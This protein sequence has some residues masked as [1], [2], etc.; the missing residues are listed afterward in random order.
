MEIVQNRALIIN[1][2]TPAKVLQSIPKSTIVKSYSNGVHG[3]LVNWGLDEARVLTNL[4]FKNVPSP[5]LRNY[6]WP[7]PF[8]PFTHQRDTAAFLTVRKRAFCFNEM[9]TGKTSSCIWAADYLQQ[10]GVVNRVLVICPLSIMRSAWE[11]ELF[12]LCPQRTAVVAHGDKKAR[13]AAING[14]APWVIIN[15]DGIKLVTAELMAKFDLIIVDEA[16]AFKTCTSERWKTL[17]SLIQPTTWL[18]LLTG[19]PASQSPLDAYGLAK[20]VSPEK[21]PRHFTAWRELV[22]NKINMFK[23]VPRISA[24]ETVQ[25]ALQPAIRYAKRDCIDLP[26]IMYE[27]RSV[28]MTAQ[29]KK[30]Y[31]MMVNKLVVETQEARITAVNAAAKMQKLLQIACGAA[32]TDEP[33]ETMQFD[34]G[35][36]LDVLKEVIDGTD[37]KVLIAVPYRNALLRLQEE[38]GRH[39]MVDVIHGGVS[40]GKRTDIFKAFQESD[41]PRILLIQPQAAAHGVTLTAADTIIWYAP[42]PSFEYFAQFNARIDRPGQTNSMLVVQLEGSP[43]ERRLNTLLRDR[44]MSSEALLETFL[45]L[46]S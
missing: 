24:Q 29:Q 45:H 13:L 46:D 40:A 17:N 34:I 16:N 11:R 20:L 2:K 41:N 32:Y 3:L 8:T 15:H 19:T 22:M 23:W 5:I 12:R 4:G 25:T 44:K 27:T 33:E 21:V 42:I 10:K 38:L 6:E 36:R 14:N 43:V 30:Y 18:W 9:G 1:T 37:N 28:E 35:S 39:Y 7:G 26:P 31:Q